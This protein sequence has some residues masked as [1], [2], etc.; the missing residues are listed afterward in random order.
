MNYHALLFDADGVLIKNTPL[1]SERLS[2]E[3]GIPIEKMLLFFNGAFM[4]CGIGKADLKEELTKVVSHWG[5]RGTVDELLEFWLT[6]GTEVDGEMEAFI[7]SLYAQ[8][9]PTYL[10]THQEKYRGEHFR[11][12]FEGKIFD[13]VYYSAALGIAKGEKAFWEKVFAGVTD[14]VQRKK[15]IVPEKHLCLFIDDAAENIKDAAAFGLQTYQ[16]TG[17]IAALKEALA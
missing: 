6:K 9:V 13:R 12:L 8:G 11:T 14:D 15:G 17:D 16:Y 5:W 1:F 7:R 4:Q 3:Y 10:V 2:E